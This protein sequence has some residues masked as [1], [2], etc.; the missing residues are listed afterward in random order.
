MQL[1]VI[2]RS[3]LRED[4]SRADAIVLFC[5]KKH[6]Y[7]YTYIFFISFSSRSPAGINETRVIIVLGRERWTSG[8]L[9]TAQVDT[10]D[11]GGGDAH[12]RRQGRE[13]FFRRASVPR[14]IYFATTPPPP[15]MLN[16]MEIF[17]RTSTSPN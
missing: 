17:D 5:R 9:S 3:L 8:P 16:D 10:A 1:A 11:C 14:E 6:I 15:P 12:T 2:R 13:S 4:R 7:I